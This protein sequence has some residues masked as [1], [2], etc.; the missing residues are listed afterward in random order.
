[1]STPDDQAADDDWAAALAEQGVTGA[2]A[3]DSEL[4]D[5]WVRRPGSGESPWRRMG[6]RSTTA[7]TRPPIRGADRI[8]QERSISRRLL[9]ARLPGLAASAPSSICHLVAN[10]ADA[11]LLTG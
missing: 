6:H 7:S 8:S 9:P 1:V 2:D 5:D 3:A 11:R 10:V 4:A